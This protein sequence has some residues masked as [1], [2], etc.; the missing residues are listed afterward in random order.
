L[1]RIPC[2]NPERRAGATVERKFLAA[3]ALSRARHQQNAVEAKFV[4]LVVY[5]KRMDRSDESIAGD[6]VLDAG[7]A[8]PD[9]VPA[10]AVDDSLGPWLPHRSL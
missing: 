7:R 4:R 3:Y 2:G 8:Q 9:L 1:R 6:V 10:I 5:D